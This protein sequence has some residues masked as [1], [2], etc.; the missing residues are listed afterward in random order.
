MLYHEDALEYLSTPLEDEA[1]EIYRKAIEEL[2]KANNEVDLIL[3]Y[4]GGSI[5][6]RKHLEKKLEN[7]ARQIRA[8]LLYI[9]EK[10][11]VM[12]EANG[13]YNFV[14]SAL[15]E[16]LKETTLAVAK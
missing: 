15:F 16:K 12:L 7:V 6:M 11:A 4:G 9:E 2:E 3:V 13:L 10:D 5:L 1:E 14:N 8:K